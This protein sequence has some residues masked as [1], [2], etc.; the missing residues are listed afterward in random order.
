MPV[1][2]AER[3][4]MLTVTVVFTTAINGWQATVV[5]CLRVKKTMRT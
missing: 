3:L 2:Q 5:L 1:H 4:P